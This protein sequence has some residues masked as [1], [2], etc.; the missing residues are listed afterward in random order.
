MQTI[1]KAGVSRQI[2]SPPPGIYLI[3]YGDRSKGNQG[4]HDDLTAT[5]VVFADGQQRV[6]IVACDLLAINSATAARVQAR[7][8]FPVLISCS[9]TH[10]GPITYAH[11]RSPRKNRDYVRL[12]VD[13]ISQAVCDAE[14]ALEPVVASWS[15]GQTGI[16]VNR[17]ERLVDGRIEIGVN[18][19]GPVDRSL[20]V[21]QLCRED[22]TPLATLVNFACHGTV[23]G[24]K[25]LLVSADW[26][27]AMRSVVEAATDAPCLFIQGAT[28]DMNPVINVTQSDWSAVHELGEQVGQAVLETFPQLA[29]IEALPIQYQQVKVWLPLLAAA[30]TSKP[31]AVHRKVLSKVAK[32]P[33]LLV[34]FILNQRYPWITEIEACGGV[35]STPMNVQV[36]RLGELAYVGYGMEVFTEIGIAVKQFSPARYTIFA[37]LTSGCTGYLPTSSEHARGGYEV[38][39]APYFYRLPGIFDPGAAGLVQAETQRLLE[40]AW[41]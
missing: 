33:S 1:L 21:L 4:I 16:A 28:G 37:S 22:N 34:D 35:W 31:P 12:L 38:E 5:A 3:G 40:Q 32:V 36:V 20:G 29:S 24:P 17:R 13:R 2:I 25:S 11:E 19:D 30:D 6:A 10:S 15:A 23:M 26:P 39:Q 9:H 27:G 18:P 41:L 7:L 14:K 8:D